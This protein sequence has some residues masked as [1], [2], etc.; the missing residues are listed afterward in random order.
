VTLETLLTGV[1]LGSAATGLITFGIALG[2][3]R[4]RLDRGA[5]V[6]DSISVTLAQTLENASANAR[7]LTEVARQLSDLVSVHT[8]ER[9]NGSGFG[10]EWLRQPV[11]D[12]IR[13]QE[14]MLKLIEEMRTEHGVAHQLIIDRL[15]PAVK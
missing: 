4:G 14:A 5:R 11:A 1:A 6:L 10:T 7:I 15:L 9:A 12:F 8:P 13:R 2:I 3:L